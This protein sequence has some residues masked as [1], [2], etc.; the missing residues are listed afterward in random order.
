MSDSVTLGIDV[1][2][3]S[4][5]VAALHGRSILWTAKGQYHRPGAPQ[6]LEAITTATA[7]RAAEVQTVGLCVPG[8]L[9][10]KREQVTFSANVPGLHGV[11]LA[12]LASA[13]IG[14]QPTTTRIIN[15]TLASAWDVYATRHS[16]GRLLVLAL[17][18]GV[19][20]C[21]LDEGVPLRVD[22]DSPGHIGQIDV[23]V[24]G[25]PVVAPDGGAGGL[26][27][28]V[29]AAA[30]RRR[31]GSGPVS[32]KLRIEDAP[33]R[34]LVKAI[35]ICHALYRPNH[36]VLAGGLGIRLGHLMPD[37]R[38]AIEDQITSLARPGWTFS[39]G[40]SDHHAACGAARLAAGEQ[41]ACGR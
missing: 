15:D 5:K 30:L 28:Y 34:A 22:G 10:D 7:G 36:I 9:D 12:D 31:Y 40:D 3:T 18:T 17:G 39:T 4:V 19:G 14:H 27:G 25:D 13:A 24:E 8:V 35:R 26:E 37:L 6:I 1:G 33:M 41:A 16:R 23:G 32:P 29:G 38:D 20:A 11:R 2:G 21:V